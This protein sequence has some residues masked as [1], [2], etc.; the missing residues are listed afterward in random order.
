MAAAEHDCVSFSNLA[1]VV[2]MRD[3]LYSAI[4][5]CQLCANL[6]S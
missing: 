5:I 1:A 6:H 2:N 3:S 4:C